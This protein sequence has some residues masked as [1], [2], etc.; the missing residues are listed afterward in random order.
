MEVLI[1]DLCKDRK[2]ILN[3]T[4]QTIADKADMSVNTVNTYFS[5]AS[6]APSVYTVGPI[7]AALGVSLDRYFGINNEETPKESA[8]KDARILEL[9]QKC[10]DYKK[11]IS[12]QAN[13]ISL[14]DEAIKAAQEEVRRRRPI[15]YCLL[16]ITALVVIAFLAYLLHFDLTNPN[17]GLFRG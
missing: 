1:K 14:K 2:N 16:G 13:I 9:E 3:Y 4:N 8:E 15:I 11:D 12:H 6:K 10:R 17:Y 5:T 7:C